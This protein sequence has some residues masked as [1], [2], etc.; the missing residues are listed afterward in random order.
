LS[1]FDNEHNLAKKERLLSEITQGQNVGPSLMR[2]AASTKNTDTRWM[3]MRGMRDV[4]CLQCIGFLEGSLKDKD[5]LVRANAARALGDLG[6]KASG[7]LVLN[8]FIPESD[9]GALEQAS[10][11]LHMLGVKSACPYIREKIPKYSWQT[12]AWLLQALGALGSKTD[13]PFIAGYLDSTDKASAMMAAAALEELTGADFG[14][15]PSG[16]SGYPPPDLV[17][18][19]AWWASQK[20]TWPDPPS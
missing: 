2:L 7:Q 9:P 18:A 4:H 16:P 11:A 14:P 8:M 13:V 1:D 19:R 12:R 20:A 15:H 6:A 10:L 17:K 5:A 3:A